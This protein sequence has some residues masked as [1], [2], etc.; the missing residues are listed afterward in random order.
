M[1]QSVP[2]NIQSQGL[3]PCIFPQLNKAFTAPDT[4]LSSSVNLSSD[5]SVQLHEFCKQSDFS[6]R[7]VVQATWALVLRSYVGSDSTLFGFRDSDLGNLILCSDQFHLTDT[8]EEHLKRSSTNDAG[9]VIGNCSSTENSGIDTEHNLFN[10][11][12]VLRNE[13]KALEA[14][15]Q[16][17]EKQVKLNSSYT[18]DTKLM[19]GSTQL[20][21]SSI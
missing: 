11:I 13:Y 9:L 3:E 1:A 5:A 4:R 12:I 6:L 14:N 20:K 10:S 8:V 17:A 16:R 15:N 7:A 2:A 18:C 21:W 19:I